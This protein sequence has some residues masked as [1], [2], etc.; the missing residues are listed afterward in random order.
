[1]PGRLCCAQIMS[2]CEI[3]VLPNADLLSQAAGFLDS[4]MDVLLPVKGNSML[5]FIRSGKDLALVRKEKEVR[6]GDVVLALDSTGQYVIHRVVRIEDDGA[7]TLKGDGNLYGT[8]SCTRKDVLGT[9]IEVRKPSGKVLFPRHV[10]S[11]QKMPVLLR[12]VILALY[13][14]LFLNG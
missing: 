11:W 5:P 8:E 9:V 1:M 10:R 12:R 4:G 2:E 13:K 7:M 14:R 3:K 6:E